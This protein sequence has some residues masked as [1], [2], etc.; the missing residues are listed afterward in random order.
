MAGDVVVL[1]SSDDAD[2]DDHLF[3]TPSREVPAPRTTAASLVGKHT[4]TARQD[5]DARAASSVNTRPA[6]ICIEDTPAA[7]IQGDADGWNRLRPA[8]RGNFVDMDMPSDGLPSLSSSPFPLSLSAR[9]RLLPT[10]PAAAQ[11]GRHEESAASAFGHG[12][13]DGKMM[14]PSCGRPSGFVCEVSWDESIGSPT[15]L[16]EDEGGRDPRPSKRPRLGADATTNVMSSARDDDAPSRS[17]AYSLRSPFSPLPEDERE[18][19]REDG[20]DTTH[21]PPQQTR[22]PT[23]VNDNVDCIDLLSSSGS[24][25]GQLASTRAPFDRDSDLDDFDALFAR[26]SARPPQKQPKPPPDNNRR[27]RSVEIMTLSSSSPPPSRPTSS[28]AAFQRPNLGRT[29]HASLSSSL[30]HREGF[31]GRSTAAFGPPRPRQRLPLQRSFSENHAFAFT[32]DD[33][34][35]DDDDDEINDREAFAN[36]IDHLVATW[37]KDNSQGQQPAGPTRLGSSNAALQRRRTAPDERA[38]ARGRRKD[39]GPVRQRADT[40]AT[41]TTAAAREAEKEA[42]RREKEAERAR[43]QQQK[44][45]DKERRRIAMDMAKEKKTAE[46]AAAAAFN[47]ANKSRV[48]K[49]VAAPEMIVR[50]PATLPQ[51]TREV[52]ETLLGAIKAESQPWTSPVGNVVTWRRKVT[53]E[54]DA[55]LGHWVPVAQRVVDE[56]HALVVLRG[57]ELVQLIVAA[58]DDPMS[59][60]VAQTPLPPPPPLDGRGGGLDGH[61]RTMQ[62]HF[63]GH[64]LL[65]LVEGLN[66][67]KSKNRSIRNRQFAAAVRNA[68]GAAAIAGTGAANTADGGDDA[69][70]TT[71]AAATRP[72]DRLGQ[73]GRNN[74]NSS[75]D[76]RRT[77]PRNKPQAVDE[78]RVDDALLALQVAHE[79]VL[80]HE[81]ASALDTARWIKIFTEQLATAPYRQQTEARYAAAAAFCMDRGQIASGDGAAETYALMLQQIGRVTEPV[82]QGIAAR[83]P[84]VPKLVRGLAAEGPLALEACL[85]T[86]NRHGELSDRTVGP[87]LSRRIYNV[88]MGQDERST[89]V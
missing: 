54:Y 2:G 1:L 84:T 83:F 53:A 22:R 55:A 86:R 11:R 42:R 38:A 67:W 34:D 48:D 15:R 57:D 73:R 10:V 19:E 31:S 18:E 16:D 39:A 78:A 81:T 5:E 72:S 9:K 61:V 47:D 79:G 82:A 87:A 17:L 74:N 13:D 56:R 88:F 50:L 75:N 30:R 24:D 65:Y 14:D 59:A 76:H 6:V 63:P 51:A 8:R 23:A 32:D 28:S 43:R 7:V 80:V 44:E 46:R 62:Q 33:D 70:T 52:T 49:A 85:R 12:T 89:D 36:H 58:D 35:K 68:G 71:A 26:T 4:A 45:V 64:T 69:E 77:K 60:D 29:S 66:A 3:V 27:Q 21:L 25:T 37:R 41:A 20:L 40:T